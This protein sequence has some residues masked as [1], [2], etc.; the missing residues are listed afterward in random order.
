[1]ERLLSPDVMEKNLRELNSMYSS[2]RWYEALSPT[3][4]DREWIGFRI[5]ELK[6]ELARRRGEVRKSVAHESVLS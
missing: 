1:M 2:M 5:V 6:T 3:A 4:E